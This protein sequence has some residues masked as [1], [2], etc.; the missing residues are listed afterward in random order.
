MK[1]YTEE[2]MLYLISLVTTAAENYVR[3]AIAN[4]TVSVVFYE[5]SIQN[6][7]I[8]CLVENSDCIIAFASFIKYR[9]SDSLLELIEN[10][11]TPYLK[12][13]ETREVCFNVNGKNN[14]IIEFVRELGFTTDMEGFQLKYSN[15]NGVGL[16][17]QQL[18]LEKG[19]TPD[20]LEKFINLFDRAY[21]KLNK[22]N[23][24]RTDSCQIAPEKFLRTFNGY[25]LEK[26]VQSFWLSD[27]LVGAYVTKGAYIRDF[28][29]DPKYQN[30]GY[31][32]I[33]L[34][35]CISRMRLHGM[36]NIY[37]RVAKTN[38][39]AKRFYEKNS[40]IEISCFAEHTYIS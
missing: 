31:G 26:Q 22:D 23:G 35:S 14:E 12:A 6:H 7:G 29:I 27:Q 38:I 10:K 3:A 13:T 32:S 20:M 18:F 28:V 37:L 39:E 33:I 8:F 16:S 11:I 5:E 19:F 17:D 15:N 36:E 21:Y 1:R 40:F 24:W 2:K 4:K 30:L 25:N 34:K 9:M